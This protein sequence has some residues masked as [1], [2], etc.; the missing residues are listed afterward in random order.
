MIIVLQTLDLTA[1]TI[2]IPIMYLRILIINI[3]T[4]YNNVEILQAYTV[5]TNV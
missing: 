4:F 5:K 1:K 3:H 2:F